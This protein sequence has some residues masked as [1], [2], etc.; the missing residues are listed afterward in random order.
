MVDPRLACSCQRVSPSATATQRPGGANRRRRH[1]PLAARVNNHGRGGRLADHGRNRRRTRSAAAAGFELQR[2][3]VCLP[4]LPCFTPLRNLA[5]A[6]L[7][8]AEHTAPTVQGG[9]RAA[10]LPRI[11]AIPVA[12]AVT[13]PKLAVNAM[14]LAHATPGDATPGTVV[15]T[16]GTVLAMT[17]VIATMRPPH[18]ATNVMSIT[19]LPAVHA[20]ILPLTQAVALATTTATPAVPA[21]M[22]AN[23]APRS[24][25]LVARVPAHSRAPCRRTTTSGFRATPRHHTPTNGARVCA[26]RVGDARLLLFRHPLFGLVL[27]L[28]RGHV[29]VA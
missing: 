4:A 21:A 23:T 28:C 26:R 25:S 13:S 24:M 18:A 20:T 9:T 14:I 12:I 27:P 19:R 22:L 17:A 11:T 15:V 2:R 29:Q 8:A 10:T 5:A 6:F 3:L 16:D 1:P 7:S